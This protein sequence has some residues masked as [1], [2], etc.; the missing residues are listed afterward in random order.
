MYDILIVG[1]GPA[2][3]TA[4]IYALRN[5]K[6]V[7]IFEGNVPGGQVVTT[8]FVENYP[9]YEKIAGPDLAYAMFDQ[10]MK[11]GVELIGSYVK[12]IKKE[13][14]S[15]LVK[16]FDE[17]EFSGKIVIIATGT[18][19][20]RLEIPS[21]GKFVNKGISWCAICDGSLYKGKEVAVVGGGNSALEE[22][23]YLANL[24]SRVYLI[25]RRNEFRAEKHIVD[26]VKKLSNVEFVL[27]SVIEEFRGTNFLESVVVRNLKTEEVKVLPVSACF[28]YIGQVPATDFL[29]DLNI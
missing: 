11:L 4:A 16:T 22:T 3:L 13:K 28:E 29:K 15:F 21:E 18:K 9:G 23:I 6:K 14:D 7:A 20:K 1:A 2:G 25:H 26:A 27:D 10:A 19:Q 5:N 12:E 8:A 24:A 17:E